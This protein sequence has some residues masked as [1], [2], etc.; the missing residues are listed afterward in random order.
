MAYLEDLLAKRQALI[1]EARGIYERAEAAKSVPSAEDVQ[2]FDALMA[3]ADK[4]DEQIERFRAVEVAQR[5]FDRATPE[6][7]TATAG[8]SRKQSRAEAL[9]SVEYR[10]AFDAWARSGLAGVDRRAMEAGETGEG[11]YWV[12]TDFERRLVEVARNLTPMRQ[13]S[14]VYNWPNDR[15]IPIASVHATAA[16]T[17]EEVQYTENTPTSDQLTISALKA[18]ALMKVSEEL[19]ADSA[20]DLATY[21]TGDQAIGAINTLENTAYT[22]GNGSTQPQGVV[23]RASSGVTAASATAITTDEIIDLQEALNP[24]YWLR[25]RF[26][27]SQSTRKHLRKLKDAS[28]QY[29]WQAGL[30]AGAVDTLAGWPVT[31]NPDMAT[32]ATGATTVLAGDFSFFWIV[33]RGGYFLQRLNELYAEYGQVGFRA[34]HRSDSNLILTEAVKKLVQA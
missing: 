31:I 30:Q 6:R 1:I 22:T 8:P 27:F 3:D 14:T 4:Y 33:D 25:G 26:M 9:A 24:R 5:K 23:G 15:Q 21:L 13:I 10:E 19:M 17:A 20:F 7:E 11:G 2:R 32:I 34:F 29:I 18:T 16:W 28:G 12:P